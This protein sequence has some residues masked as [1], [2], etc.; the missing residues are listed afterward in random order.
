M[1]PEHTRHMDR[2]DPALLNAVATALREYGLD[3]GFFRTVADLVTRD[4]DEWRAC[5]GSGCDPCIL[6]IAP[7]VDRARQILGLRQQQS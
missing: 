3:D 7:A 6:V 1:E 5:C 4:S 2:D